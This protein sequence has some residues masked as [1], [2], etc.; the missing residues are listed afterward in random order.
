MTSP[1][2]G[3]VWT[4]VAAAE[5]GGEAAALDDFGF[6]AAPAPA[7]PAAADDF[8]FD[9]APAPAP[10]AADASADLGGFDTS[11]VETAAPVAA[12]PV[13]FE[14][15]VPAKLQAFLDRQTENRAARKAAAENKAEEM[16]KA[17]AAAK[18]EMTAQRATTIEAKRKANLAADA[19]AKE[20]FATESNPWAKIVE[21]CDM[22]PKAQAKDAPK[23]KDTTRLRGM[24]LDL[25]H[26]PIEAK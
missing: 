12:A 4:C 2:C 25:K 10:P 6:D 11:P 5:A 21:Y 19:A 9:A 16:K 22:K 14:P 3:C 20:F 13:A 23:A 18:E 24:L 1:V 17:G 15:A 26:N 7:A 8:G